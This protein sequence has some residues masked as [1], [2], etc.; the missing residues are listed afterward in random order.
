M[1]MGVIGTIINFVLAGDEALFPHVTGARYFLA[2][3][4]CPVRTEQ[5][6]FEFGEVGSLRL[7]LLIS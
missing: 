5:N 6:Y 7:L 3:H 1:W 4:E 2:G